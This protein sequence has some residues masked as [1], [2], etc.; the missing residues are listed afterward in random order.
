[1]NEKAKKKA[2][3]IRIPVMVL[4]AFCAVSLYG[5]GILSRE[6]DTDYILLAIMTFIAALLEPTIVNI[7]KY[8]QAKALEEKLMQEKLERDKILAEKRKKEREAEQARLAEERRKEL[9]LASA[10]ADDQL[11]ARAQA[12]SKN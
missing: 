2:F 9:L 1:M 10:S 11:R 4:S 5:L 6:M 12:R 7:F 8:Y 3:D